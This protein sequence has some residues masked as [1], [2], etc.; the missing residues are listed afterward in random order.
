[1]PFF[2]FSRPSNM[3]YIEGGD[4]HEQKETDRTGAE[5]RCC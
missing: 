2:S 4:K 1:M 3:P 5:N